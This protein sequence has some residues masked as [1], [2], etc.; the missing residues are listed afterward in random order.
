MARHKDYTPHGVI[1]AALLAFGPGLLPGVG[2]AAGVLN[3]SEKGDLREAAANLFDFL[4]R[5]D[6]TKAARIAV[7]AIPKDGLGAAINDRLRRAAAPRAT[8]CST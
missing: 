2:R 6:D 7:M 4:H 3:L 5:L 1:P 8:D